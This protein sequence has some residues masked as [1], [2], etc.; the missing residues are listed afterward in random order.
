MIC[1]FTLAVIDSSQFNFFSKIYFSI[2][3]R[4]NEEQWNLIFNLPQESILI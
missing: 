2:P 1:L 4:L 3:C